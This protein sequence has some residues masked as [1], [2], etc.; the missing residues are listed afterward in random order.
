MLQR[1]VIFLLVLCSALAACQR[2]S[3]AIEEDGPVTVGIALGGGSGTSLSFT[4]DT[5]TSATEDGLSDIWSDG[6]KIALWAYGTNDN[7]VLNAQPFSAYSVSEKVSFFT[8]TL[9]SQM[10]DALYSYFASYPLPELI[11][12]GKARYNI[13][14]RQ[15]GRCSNGAGLLFSNTATAGALKAIDWKGGNDHSE[16]R[17]DMSPLIHRLRFYMTATD[18]LEGEHIEEL[19]VTF[20]RAVAGPVDVD[21]SVAW[22]QTDTKRSAVIH[23]AGENT[24]TVLTDRPVPESTSSE[25][26]Y[27]NVAMVPTTFSAG[28]SMEVTI[29]T[30][31]KIAF[32]TI[33]LQSRTFSAGHSTPVR[34]IPTKI[35]DCPRLFFN[36]ASNPVGEDIQSIKLTA[37]QGC[38]WGAS[39]TNVITFST[40]EL[41]KPG[42]TFYAE[43]YDFSQFES[44][45][46]KE[47]QVTYESEHLTINQKI[48]LGTLAG[49]ISDKI[50]LNVPWLLNENFN[51]VSSFSSHDEYGTS[52]AGSKNPYSFLNGWAG[53]RI[54][55]EAGKCIRIACRRETS[56]R[57]DARVESA[58]LNAVFKKPVNL[59]V[60]FDYG[61]NNQ[62]GGIP[63]IYDGNVGQNCNIGYI[64]T[65]DNYKSGDKDGTYQHSFYIKEY[66][67]SYD[68]TPNN[69]SFIL[70]NVP[71]GNV[72]RISWRT[73][74]ESQAGT[75]NT[76]AWFYIDNVKVTISKQ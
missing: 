8:S 46:G 74:I 44:F 47:I 24:I 33:P 51:G 41:I 38:N 30:Q 48:T 17:L 61:A 5:K 13:P 62:F 23:G 65:T 10:P 56:A 54:G 55:A 53:A 70:Q 22:A 7:C 50:D 6:D 2:V 14:S 64:T 31:S 59:L 71:A 75:T 16:L 15:D 57:Y 4:S 37:P 45:G 58:P 12:N 11:E 36:L 1:L 67:G 20:P 72:V 27:I 39:G 49:K 19:K 69:D 40:S 34:I 26:H 63:I 76:T 25:R 28:E 66:S 68:S 21:L 43:F 3:V 73:V 52:K 32:A 29:H 60:E 35:M 9:P 42:D 18:G